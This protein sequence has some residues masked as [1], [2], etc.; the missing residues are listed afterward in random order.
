MQSTNL[1]LYDSLIERASD[2]A[3]KVGRK[4]RVLVT[5]D[6]TNNLYS[7]VAKEVNDFAE[8]INIDTSF[9]K[10]KLAEYK[11]Y[12][13]DPQGMLNRKTKI[14]KLDETLSMMYSSFGISEEEVL[15]F[16][17]ASLE[18][19]SN[20]ADALLG[21][22]DVP[23][24]A[25]IV[26]CSLVLDYKTPSA[27][28][29]SQ[30]RRLDSIGIV[31]EH[32]DN[33]FEL[34]LPDGNE[35]IVSY[36]IDNSD[37]KGIVDAAN[38]ASDMLSNPIIAFVSF[39]TAGSSNHDHPGLMKRASEMYIQSG[40]RGVCFGD[41]QLDASLDRHIM[42]KK[43]GGYDPFNGENANCLIYSDATSAHSII[44]Y[45]EWAYNNY[46]GRS[47]N[48]IAISDM[49]IKPNPAPIQ[50]AQIM[51]ESISTFKL[52]VGVKPVVALIGHDKMTIEKIRKTISLLPEGYKS[53]LYSAD[54]MTLR[55]ALSTETTLFI[56]PELAY[57]NPAYK[58][59]QLLNPGFFVTQGF[60]KPVCD[61]S[62]G[63]DNSP[64]RIR[65]TIAYLCISCLDN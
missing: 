26:G 4:A 57:G 30:M 56:Y 19:K 32:P 6:I 60:E 13:D 41:I 51:I 27:I 25:M 11:G 34:T 48:I 35:L 2:L 42:L 23:T 43:L 21:G 38:R 65:S 5:D 8:L 49:A 36:P 9:A 53:Y 1:T 52:I 20:R 28:F 63:D 61:L 29:F 54:A 45:F 62:R 39:S 44:D 40:G 58:A 24:E 46:Y 10:E 22:I 17:S 37:V 15:P 3:Q 12:K 55:D 59:W 14:D 7:S 47:G 18:L 64:E 31:K 16:L 33:I 50:L